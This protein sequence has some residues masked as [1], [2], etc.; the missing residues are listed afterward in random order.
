MHVRDYVTRWRIITIA[1]IARSFAGR[2]RPPE[3]PTVAVAEFLAGDA[4]V[5]T[6]E[7]AM[8]RRDERRHGHR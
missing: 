6:R 5:A 8:D 1:S 7:R 3:E 4:G 2:L